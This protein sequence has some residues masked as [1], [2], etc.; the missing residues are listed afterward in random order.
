MYL[1]YTCSSRVE[2]SIGNKH[3]FLSDV[4]ISPQIQTIWQNILR[5]NL[6]KELRKQ[7]VIFKGTEIS[8][9]AKHE[10]IFY[11]ADSHVCLYISRQSNVWC[12][13]KKLKHN[14]ITSVEKWVFCIKNELV[15]INLV[16]F[17]F[18]K[19]FTF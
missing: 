12:I 16:K 11:S 2:I 9:I 8:A 10:C 14:F 6:I 1:K 4:H 18:T 15:E 5:F 13:E 3:L 19:I 17:S 7:T